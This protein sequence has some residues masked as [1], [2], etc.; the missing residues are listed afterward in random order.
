MNPN[1]A[2]REAMAAKA[3]RDSIASMDGDDDLLAGMIEGETQL[4]EI[5]D[6]LLQR[7]SDNRATVEGI[8]AEEARIGDRKRRY[9]KRVDADRALIGQGS[10]L[11]DA[12]RLLD[13]SRSR[14]DVLA[15]GPERER[16]AYDHRRQD[17][18]DSANDQ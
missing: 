2:K 10:R 13:G 1:D 7:I 3:L 14:M 4:F 15:S 17:E 18:K 6:R 12:E 5:I 8:V 11:G 16:D 9:E